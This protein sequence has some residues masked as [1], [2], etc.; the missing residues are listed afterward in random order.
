MTQ[1]APFQFG[2]RRLLIVTGVVA[3]IMA[4]AVRIGLVAQAFFGP[5]LL[6]LL[7]WAFFR[8]RQFAS[9]LKEVYQRR[10]EI[11]QRRV[12]LELDL[13]Q[14]VQG[15]GAMET[16]AKPTAESI[17]NTKLNDLQ[18]GDSGNGSNNAYKLQ[19]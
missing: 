12:Q 6:F 14:A 10:R 13:R 3:I 19:E 17:E 4:V 7:V 8:G 15:R 5:I 2:I 1:E 9:D 11:M 18:R 16:I